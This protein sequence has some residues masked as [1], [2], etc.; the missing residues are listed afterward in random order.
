MVIGKLTGIPISTTELEA[1]RRKTDEQFPGFG[2]IKPYKI[3]GV[4]KFDRNDKCEKKQR[5]C[6]NQKCRCVLRI[7][8]KKDFCA[9]C[10]SRNL[11]ENGLP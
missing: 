10:Q 9:P 8:N 7:G 3:K 4:P 1:Q 11:K 2:K 6:K 5:R